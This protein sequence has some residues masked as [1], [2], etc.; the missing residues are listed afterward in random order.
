MTSLGLCESLKKKN[1]DHMGGTN[2]MSK[3]TW[4]EEAKTA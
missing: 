4:T 3:D 2:I 1:K